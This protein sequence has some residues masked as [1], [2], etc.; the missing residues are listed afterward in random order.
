ME[1]RQPKVELDGVWWREGPE[2]SPTQDME[3]GCPDVQQVQLS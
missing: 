3:A 2:D 1:R